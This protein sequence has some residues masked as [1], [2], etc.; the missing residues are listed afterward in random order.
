MDVARAKAALTDLVVAVERTGGIF[1]KGGMEYLVTDP[2]WFDLASAYTK[3]CAAL[4]RDEMVQLTIDYDDDGEAIATWHETTNN[5]AV[6]L[7]DGVHFCREDDL[8]D[9]DVDGDIN[10]YG[11]SDV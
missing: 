2:E 6:L 4:G 10:A 8:D 9:G 5:I 7:I 11:D 1:Y 3:A